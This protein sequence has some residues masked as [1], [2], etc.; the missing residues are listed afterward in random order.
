MLDNLR[1]GALTDLLIPLAR[2]NLPKSVSNIASNAIN[3][4]ER[5]LSGKGG[6]SAGKALASFIS[7]ED[8]NDIIQIIK[9]LE[10]SNAL[11]YGITETVK[12]E[13][14]TQEGR[15]LPA[16]LAPLTAS[17]MQPVISSVE[18]GISGTG[19]KE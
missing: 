1:K 13:M 5:K 15:F 11:I 17:L 7:N 4:F 9:S 19:V 16:L 10:D 8:M 6:V 18:K 3:K 2:N 14:K 12:H